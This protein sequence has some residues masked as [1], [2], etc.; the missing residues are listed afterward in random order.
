MNTQKVMLASRPDQYERLGITNE[1]Q[2]FEDGLRTN[3]EQKGTFE[4]WYFDA[5]LSD[6]T[7]FVVQFQT[8]NAA[9]PNVGLEPIVSI[10][11]NLPDGRTI[12]KNAKF[13]AAQ[14]SASKEQCDVRIANNR[15]AGDLHTYSIRATLD[16]VRVDVTLTGLTDPWRPK[17]GYT[18]FGDDESAY[19]AWLPSVPYGNVT[20]TY[21]VDGV[22]TTVT[23]NVYHDHNWGNVPMASIFNNWY[24][25]RGSV[26][27]YT[28]I[29]SYIITEKKYGYAPIP[30]FML[31]RDGKVI[32][33]DLTKVTFTKQ[34]IAEDQ[35]TG[36]P[37]ADI[38]T[39]DY[40]DGSSAKIAIADRYVLTY[41]REKTILRLKFTQT[42][43]GIQRLA[44]HLIGF[45]GAYLRFSGNLELKH[46][47]GA[48]LVETLHAP[49]IWE[50]MYLGKVDHD[51]H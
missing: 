44:A 14:F 51:E 35:P 26:G 45:D 31:A 38:T 21:T 29:S 16:D 36:K 48:E 7:Q 22:T 34:Q 4:W 11:L 17:T 6:G 46:Y 18:V 50:L 28:F 42:L 3:P 49:A 15:F 12:N 13:P 8:K 47:E 24:W 19:F 30:N 33:D 25:G 39:Y 43:H 20:A 32:A 41:T 1:I 9:V 5:N 10:D 2:P 40:R 37:V 27:P 23:G